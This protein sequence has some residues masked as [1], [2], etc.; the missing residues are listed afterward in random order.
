MKTREKYSKGFV[1]HTP[2]SDPPREDK[3]EITRISFYGGE[4]VW[5]K[6]P[7]GFPGMTILVQ[8]GATDGVSVKLIREDGTISTAGE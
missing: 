6:I 7:S 3:I 4:E 1:K 2:E 5:Y 8:E